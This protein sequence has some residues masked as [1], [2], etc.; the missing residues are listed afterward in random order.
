MIRWV[1]VFVIA[2]LVSSTSLQAQSAMFTVTVASADLRQSPSASSPIVGYKSKGQNLDVRRELGSWVEVAWP[3]ASSGVA[4]ISLSMGSIRQSATPP[5]R[6]MTIAEYVGTSSGLKSTVP[7]TSTTGALA[8]ATAATCSCVQSPAV[9]AAATRA[10]ISSAPMQPLTTYVVPK[11]SLGLGG[12]IGGATRS[13]GATGRA[14]S[15][16]RIGVQLEVSSDHR[17]NADAARLSSQQIASSVL[18]A[19][20]SWVGDFLWLRPYAGGGTT[21]YRSTVN[22]ATL[23]VGETTT[24]HALGLQ[25]FGGGELTFASVPRFALSADIGYHK[26]PAALASFEP[27]RI[28]IKVSGHWYVR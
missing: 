5:R 4:Y 25:V 22:G 1:A 11:H 14:W 17:S 16:K 3:T 21:F 23:A 27:R 19:P 28:G 10:S 15:R 12:R 7:S 6:P 13:V 26:W 2:L 9:T 24:D 8:P 18:Y 20:P